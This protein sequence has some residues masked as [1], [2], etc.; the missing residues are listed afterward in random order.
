MRKT[1]VAVL[2]VC[3]LMVLSVTAVTRV[4]A[5]AEMWFG[6]YEP[7]IH[8]PVVDN[9]GDGYYEAV[10]LCIGVE[11]KYARDFHVNVYGRD[12]Y[13]VSHFI[14]STWA[15]MTEWNGVNY[16]YYGHTKLVV[17]YRGIWDFRLELYA[18]TGNVRDVRNY[19]DDPGLTDW[20]MECGLLALV[21]RGEDN[22]IYYR[23]FDSATSGSWGG[24]NAVP[25]GATI[26]SPA[27]SILG[28][29]TL[30]MVVRGTDGQSLWHCSINLTDNSFS[31]WDRVNGATNSRPTLYKDT[32][33]VR[34]LDNRVYYSPYDYGLKTFG[35][36]WNVVPS[37]TTCDAPAAC[38]S[39]IV[40][41]GMDGNSLWYSNRT[42]SG[43]QMLKGATH[44]PPTLTDRGEPGVMTKSEYEP[45]S[46]LF[47]RG[48][49]NNIYWNSAR[50]SPWSGF[51]TWGSGAT[52]DSLAAATI[53]HYYHLVVRGMDGH[54]LWW[55][56]EL[57]WSLL[58]G[59]TPSAPTLA[60]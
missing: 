7:T 2:L 50:A 16:G 29:G 45:W 40:V 55:G 13:G 26:D 49:D 51:G 25:T 17:P 22:R 38:Y 6:Y 9:D 4:C 37:G 56:T 60:S 35:T 20:K 14:L 27:A 28:Y 15:K 44:S 42:F 19:G 23:M 1:I 59:S 34:G 24:W 41:R 32:L 58:S 31:G 54:S 36:A 3:F 39:F 47:V 5:D 53:G 30:Q 57:S 10:T 8:G 21:V 43:W 33:Y 18:S 12:E 11:T 48:L 46:D 52:C